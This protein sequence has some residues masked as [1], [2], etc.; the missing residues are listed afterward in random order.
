[1]NSE[2]NSNEEQRLIMFRKPSEK[3]M[4]GLMGEFSR[5]LTEEV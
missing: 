3:M 5:K 4:C 1:M 2:V